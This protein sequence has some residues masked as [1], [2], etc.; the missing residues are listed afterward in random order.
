MYFHSLFD[1]VLSLSLIFSPWGVLGGPWWVLQMSLEL[2]G[3]LSG[4]PFVPRDVL[5]GAWGRVLGSSLDHSV[6][7]GGAH[8]YAHGR[9]SVSHCSLLNV[10]LGLLGTY[11][12]AHKHRTSC[13][14]RGLAYLGASLCGDNQACLSVIASHH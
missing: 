13:I 6:R 11:L 5:R 3:G 1:H 4:L 8:M 12:G 14:L 2:L 7:D 10:S 9:F